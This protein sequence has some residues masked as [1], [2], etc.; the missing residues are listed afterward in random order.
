MAGRHQLQRL[1]AAIAAGRRVPAD[2]CEWFS[3]ALD[4]FESGEDLASALGLVSTR[5][6]RDERDAHIQRAAELMPA[7]WST[8]EKVRRLRAAERR[9]TP[10]LYD[11]DLGDVAKPWELAAVAALRRLPLPGP[12]RL[13]DLCNASADCNFVG[14]K[15]S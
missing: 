12:R 13:H 10:L 5:T 6:L 14:F 7:H 11:G 4:R 9:L 2:V 1:R 15:W 8:A 3:D